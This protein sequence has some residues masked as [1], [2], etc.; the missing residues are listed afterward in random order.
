MKRR[1]LVSSLLLL[2]LVVPL[3]ASEQPRGELR[4]CLR[5]EPKT[6][7]PLQVS[8]DASE[9]VRYLTGGVLLRVN[10]KT[11]QLEPELATGWEVEKGGRK[12]TFTLRSG[13]YF[14]DGTPFSAEDVAYTIK[15]LMDPEIHSPTADSFHMGKGTVKTQVLAPLQVAILFPQPVAGIEALFDQLAILSARSPRKEFAVLG[16]FFMAEHKAGSYVLLKRNPNYWKKDASGRQLPYLDSVRLEIQSNRDIEALRFQ[17]G[18]LDV[19]NSLDGELYDRLSRTLPAA[20]RDLGPSL[21]SEQ[22]WFNQAPKSPV[23]SHKLQ[24][25]R[26]QAF[27]RAISLAINREDLARIVY[28][29]HARPA[30]GPVSPANQAWFNAKLP[31]LAHAPAQATELLKNAGFRLN[32]GV[33]RDR[34]GHAVEFSIVTN[35]GNKSRERMATMIQQD[36]AQIGVKVNIVT[37]DFPS[38]IERFT[39]SFDYEACLLGMVNLELDPNAQMSIWLSSG[40]NHQ[41]SP[42]QPAPE[43]TWEAELDRLMQAQAATTD[44]ATRKQHFDRVQEIVVEQSPFLYLIN[45]SALAAVSPRV[46]GATPV[47]LRPETFWNIEWLSLGSAPQKQH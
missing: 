7:H 44:Q 2:W 18:E 6:F 24:W 29:S 34:E 26:S 21:D 15:Q 33:L 16:P 20:V 10:R 3:L 43:T 36:L 27:R 45:K 40:E 9:T 14:S 37:L 19:I 5:S 13:V 39:Q 30:R 1:L 38:L 23:A 11:Q 47:P 46:H 4:M 32:D 35:S 8:D 42:R 31:P 17:R 25:F 41:W 28:G 12:I 22:L